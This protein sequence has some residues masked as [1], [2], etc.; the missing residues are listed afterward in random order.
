[1]KLYVTL[2]LLC[3]A[4]ALA[5]P[6][7][8]DLNTDINSAT[9][10]LGNFNSEVDKYIG[11]LGNFRDEITFNIAN[12]YASIKRNL[13]S[14]PLSNETVA[15]L[16]VAIDNGTKEASD[17]VFGGIESLVLVR[18]EVVKTN[19]ALQQDLPI[20]GDATD[21][22]VSQ[23]NTT[24]D[25]LLVMSIN[26]PGNFV[27]LDGQIRSAIE[28]QSGTPA[29]NI[30]VELNTI[31]DLLYAQNFIIENTQIVYDFRAGLAYEAL[32]VVIEQA[33]AGNY[34]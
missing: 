7:C 3:V 29:I 9:T 25:D 28:G 17:S 32:L 27:S 13:D 8:R 31:T 20:L 1:M 14:L 22:L 19:A 15:D 18:L 26:V 16:I 34:C 2:A 33:K 23:Y 11:N 24:N 6:V 4:Q 10:A 5:G 12:R 21:S 30:L